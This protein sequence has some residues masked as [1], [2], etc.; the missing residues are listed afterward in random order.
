MV[1]LRTIVNSPELNVRVVTADEL[2]DVELLGA[3]TNEH[4][5]P[6]PWLGGGELLMTDGLSL[7]HTRS[8]QQAYVRRLVD[9]GVHAL[10]LGVGADL[11]FT[12][13]PP[14]LVAAARD[15]R[16]PLV[17]IPVTTPF[18][19]LTEV[20][21]AQLF[22]QQFA[23]TRK[24]VD[25]QRLLTAAAARPDGPSALVAALSRLTGLWVVLCDP[26][27][28]AQAA[29]SP[30]SAGRAEL[31]TEEL[32]RVRSQGLRGSAMISDSGGS[33]RMQPVGT[34]RLRGILI[35][36][37]DMSDGHAELVA[38]LVTFTV[39]LL[40]IDLERRHA[41]QIL[42]RRPGAEVFARLL[43]GVAPARAIRLLASVGLRA[44]R[45][46]V[47]AT[48][49][50]D[51]ARQLMDEIVETI[52]EVLLREEGGEILALMPADSAELLH[53]AFRD[54]PAALGGPVAPHNCAV[55]L[56][57]AR[58]ALTLAV[59]GDGTIIDAMQLGSAQLLLQT[60]TREV[61][62]AYAD[63]V[64]GPLEATSRTRSD[65]ITSLRAFLAA[66]GLLELA[67]GTL[68]IHRHTMRGR[69]HR[70]EQAT[71]RRLDSVDDLAELWLAFQARDIANTLT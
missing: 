71:G 22:E 50:G 20:V 54:R 8:A 18:I 27:G 25:G 57:Q 56:R 9:A 42:E 17:E 41:I 1:T 70:V 28:V 5:D 59:R 68:H 15:A 53:R 13:A 51:G 4:D 30:E 61:L 40:S 62:T 2:L 36:G 55:S 43:D 6:G 3:L 29:S 44:D 52:P 33:I 7:G 67:A 49:G 34:E 47:L 66:D 23:D 46:R 45:V 64:L 31:L 14:A 60:G 39:T 65:L 38:G 26:H 32:D 10:A 19:K 48:H 16:L 37:G 21:Y 11:P 63:A 69:L 24:T 35:Y 12:T 58:H